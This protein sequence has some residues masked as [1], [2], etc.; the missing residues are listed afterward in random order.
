MNYM[1][2]QAFIDMANDFKN[3]MIIKDLNITVIKE[4]LINSRKDL[5]VTY[6]AIRLID[7]RISII[8][9]IPEIKDLIENLRTNISYCI[10]K[11]LIEDV[12]G[13]PDDDDDV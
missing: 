13:V 2:E 6:A 10:E 3:V 5:I 12:G 7:E 4:K 11:F 8:P 1:S 9:D